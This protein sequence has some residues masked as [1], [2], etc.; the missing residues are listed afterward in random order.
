MNAF[1]DSD[2]DAAGEGAVARWRGSVWV[3]ALALA[4]GVAMGALGASAWWWSREP[5]PSGAAMPIDRVERV[6]PASAPVAAAEP[7]GP[8]MPASD[9]ATAALPSPSPSRDEVA[10]PL[11]V[12]AAL[13]LAR[14]S[15]PTAT[16]SARRKQQAWRRYYQRPDIC[17][18]DRKGDFM[19]ECA[20]H[21]IRARREFE[22]L[23][24]AGK[25]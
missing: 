12:P 20:N 24:A 4:A 17:A 10:L 3:V 15:A 22:A 1:T 18:E 16:D 19:V 14:A 2:W 23:Y 6:A 8:A 25:L 7:A 21:S 13:P 5:A 9:A 11:A